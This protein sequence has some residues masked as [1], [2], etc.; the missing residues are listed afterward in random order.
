MPSPAP[1]KRRAVRGALTSSLALLLATGLHA[2]SEPLLV[3][4]GT[5]AAIQFG[6]HDVG[7]TSAAEALIISNGGSG[8]LN[9][10]NVA[11]TGSSAGDYLVLADSCTG[12]SLAP[13]E[14]CSV[15]MSFT[16]TVIGLRNANLAFT[17]NAS[18]SPQL[19]PLLG[20]AVAPGAARPT[21]GPIDARSGFP[22]YYSDQNGLALT[23]CLD[24][25]GLCLATLP[26]PAQPPSVVDGTRDNFP[27]EFF[28]W[29]L[30]GDFPTMSQSTLVEVALEGAFAAE[31]PQPAEAVVFAR[32][33]V[34]V[35]G[36][37]TAGRFYR[38]THP[39]GSEL[40]QAPDNDG[41]GEIEYT[42]DFG[43]FSIPSVLNG[44]T[45]R[46]FSTPVCSRSCARPGCELFRL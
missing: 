38:V 25:N 9:I 44:N 14:V 32:V 13:G 46:L 41:D 29:I 26:D 5:T 18:G 8:L 35:R 7:T 6:T 12:R 27:D 22:Q 1:W 45:R 36:G 20:R 24:P 43:N 21:A 40:L 16:P 39:Y 37:L 15:S 23:E 2:Q 17:N 19:V 34:R 11:P 3:I 4:K 10:T 31:V 33:R 42:N 28:Y 30:E